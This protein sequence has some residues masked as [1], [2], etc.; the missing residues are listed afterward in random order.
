MVARRVFWAC[1]ALLTYLYAVFPAIV[2]ARGLAGRPFRPKA[3][4]PTVSLIIC[5][6]NEEALIVD[7]LRNA[8]Q[9]RYPRDRL[10]I[11]VASDGSSDRTVELAS[12][13]ASDGVKVLDLPRL[14][15]NGAISV[16][17]AASTGQILVFNDA[18]MAMTP[19]A[20]ARLAEAL[21]DPAVGGVAGE[22]RHRDHASRGVAR[23]FTGASRQ[24]QV[25]L[26]RGGSITIAG[27][28]YAV[29]REHFRPVPSSVVDDFFI[30]SQVI[31]DAQRLVF[32]PRAATYPL[33]PPRRVRAPFARSMR[34]SVQYLHSY[35]QLAPLFDPRRSGFYA[36]Q[37]ASHK[38][39][40]RFLV[41]PLV[42]LMAASL[43]LWTAGRVYRAV[44]LLHAGFHLA[45]ISALLMRT[46][47]LPTGPALRG[48]LRFERELLAAGAALPA[49]LAT[50]PADR[51]ESHR[52]GE[53]R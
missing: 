5:A 6:H 4:Q 44:T 41:F 52:V 40:R 15:K 2:I 26:S 51:W 46:L 20:I 32:E 19:D 53:G 50:G 11:I 45:A 21:G 37:L 49:A 42:A 22:R 33:G 1:I 3:W 39:L 17:A 16:A 34:M 14:G 23:L 12:G 18:D 9:L 24:F 10:E 25:L 7:K 28:L 36:L 29:R 47:G 38:V 30:P 31:L 27:L 43:Q 35:V 8:L 13:F 48:V